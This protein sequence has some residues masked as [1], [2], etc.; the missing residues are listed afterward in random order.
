MQTSLRHVTPVDRVIKSTRS[1]RR[2]RSVVMPDCDGAEAAGS[3][4]VSLFAELSVAL[5]Q[6]C[7]QPVSGHAVES[8]NGANSQSGSR[9]VA[10]RQSTP[11]SDTEQTTKPPYGPRVPQRAARIL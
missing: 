5:M 2:A 11:E 9:G 3:L 8:W 4:L 10:R 1:T 6:R 7:A